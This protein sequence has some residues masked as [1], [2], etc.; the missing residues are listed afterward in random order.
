LSH[1][2]EMGKVDL[3]DVA[4]LGSWEWIVWVPSNRIRGINWA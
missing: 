2:K 3:D 1:E 4:D